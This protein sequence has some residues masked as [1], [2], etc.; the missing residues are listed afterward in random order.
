MTFLT[1][2]SFKNFPQDGV[3]A[4]SQIR[5]FPP[6]TIFTRK[7]ELESSPLAFQKKRNNVFETAAVSMTFKNDVN[8]H[9]EIS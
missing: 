5:L 2:F 8:L 4:T 7:N 6:K 1:S 3:L 9:C